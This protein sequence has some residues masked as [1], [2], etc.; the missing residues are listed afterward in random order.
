MAQVAEN[1]HIGPGRIF[2][3]T[4]N[5]ATGIPPTIMPHTA[6]VPTPGI[7]VGY[8]DGDLVFRKTNETVEIMAEQAMGPIAVAL[9]GER[10]EVE[11]TALERVYATLRAAFDNTG[12]VTDANKH[13]FYGGG[14]QYALRTQAV[15]ITSLRPNQVGKYEVSTIYKAVSVN[16]FETAYRKS[17]ASSYR[18]V[19]RGLMDTARSIGD[20]LYQ[21]YIEI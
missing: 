20:Q 2:L 3:G 8:T 19:L 5:P 15:V 17:A 9:T 21:H 7:E 13:L 16:G 4:T 1:V 6:G 12:T 11:F 14:S 18:I 10:V